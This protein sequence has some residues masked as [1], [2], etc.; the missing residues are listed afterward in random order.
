M[1]GKFRFKRPRRRLAFLLVLLCGL[2]PA[3]CGTPA[4]DD[5]ILSARVALT[6]PNEVRVNE[7]LKITYVLTASEDLRGEWY[8]VCWAELS[9]GDA[10]RAS[11]RHFKDKGIEFTAAGAG[12]YEITL[13]FGW[14]TVDHAG[15]EWFV[16]R[17]N[18]VYAKD[19]M[20]IAVL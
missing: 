17:A 13:Y 11:I 7:T 10:E 3:A 19:T 14:A 1:N 12:E 4:R 2:V 15:G 16:K 8:N 9:G 18:T 6:C 5:K 20:R